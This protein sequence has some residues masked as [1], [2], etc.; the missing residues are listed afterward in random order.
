MA[1]KT[2]SEVETKQKVQTKYERKIEERKQKEANDKK[3]E[4]RFKIISSVVVAVLIVGIVGGI[5]ATVIN[6]Q[7]ALKSAYVKIGEEEVTKL[8]FDY[9]YNNV[10]NNYLTLYSS[11]LPY[12]GLDTTKDFA[13][14]PFS[15]ELS[16]KDM[17]DQ[18]T[19]EHM[20]QSFALLADAEAKGYEYDVEEEYKN[21]VE[22][23]KV[24]AESA[25]KTV[26]DYYKTMYGSY[27]TEKNMEPLIKQDILTGAYYNELLADNAPSD[28][29]VKAYY[30]ANKAEYDK[31]DYR[32]FAFTA[33]LSEEAS[34]EEI[35]KAMEE[36]KE[37]ADAF[38]AAREG[39]SEFEALC[40]ENAS[41]EEKANYEDEETEYSFNE[42]RYRSGIP[43]VVA[44]WL[45]DDA[46]AEGE[47]AVIADEENHKYY[48]M[49][50]AKK[51]YDEADDAKISST[52]ASERVTE[53]VQNLVERFP[54]SDEKG[55]L[56]Y[57]TVDM[58]AGDETETETEA[59]D[60]SDEAATEAADAAETEA[61][62]AAE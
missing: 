59:T 29:E 38:V 32:S 33:E 12:L 23:I 15:E 30:E 40:L 53:Y 2:V 20:S 25:G 51:Y 56:K 24:M 4:R 50:F 13:E 52:I 39:G 31:V 14:Q 3:D 48:V 43:T 7:T 28:E 34:E 46:R 18:M 5:A 41:E 62:N 58:S 17:F 60:A 57:L 55:N 27:A 61:E 21:R 42:G 26:P 54:V 8:E 47:L 6:K 45:Y 35:T 22:S 49:E 1:K 16:W 19:V 9:Y 10:V 44:E 37:K 36:L 11:L